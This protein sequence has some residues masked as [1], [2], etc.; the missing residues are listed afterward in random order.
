MGG[1]EDDRDARTHARNEVRGRGEEARGDECDIT[2]RM[3]SYRAARPDFYFLGPFLPT[4][5]GLK[6]GDHGLL[7][8]SYAL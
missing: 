7:S 8:V 5:V 1:D 4:P 3:L 2:R 6:K